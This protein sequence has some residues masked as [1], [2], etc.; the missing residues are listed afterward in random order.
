MTDELEQLVTEATELTGAAP[1]DVL[2][3]D[4]PV[5]ADDALLA[6][7]DESVYLVG[8]IG[9][10]DVGKSSLVNALAGQQITRP[11]SHGP[12]TEHAIAYAHSSAVEEVRALLEREL[13]GRYRIVAHASAALRRQVLLDLPDVDSHWSDHVLVTRRML[14][15]ILFPV[16]IQSIEKYADLAPQQL[17]AKVAEGNDPANFVFVLNKIDQLAARDG[18]AGR[19]GGAPLNELR[20]DFAK[21]IARTLSMTDSPRVHAISATHADEGDLPALRQLLAREKSGD[22]VRRSQQLAVRRRDRSLL[23]WI[24]RQGL[25]ER[26]QVLARLERDAHDALAARLGV[27][28]LERALPRLSDDPGH[29]LAMVEPALHRRLSRWPVV[30]VIDSVL[31]PLLALVRRNLSAARE[32]SAARA[33]DVYLEQEARTVASLAQ[34]AFAHL[35]QTHPLVGQLYRQHKLWE[36][37]PAEGAAADLRQRLGGA[38]DRQR[39]VIMERVAGGSGALTAPIRWLLTIGAL[40]WFPFVQPMLEAFLAGSAGTTAREL[41]YLGVQMLG[42]TYL[43]KNVTFLIIWFAVLWLVLRWGTHRRASRL[44][45]RWSGGARLDDPLSLSGQVIQWIDDLLEPI[46]RHR[47]RVEVVVK[48]ADEMRASMSRAEAA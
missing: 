3:E 47:E 21:R 35:H 31:A 24:D 23:D 25:G 27:P 41:L 28:L 43:L 17:L 8:I 46:H 29:R 48:R 12:G 45:N 44:L 42:V 36:Q 13:P 32:G 19:D 14:R 15:H 38:I 6:P 39:D 1:P 33:L 30:N 18:G 2:D 10:K 5:L 20:D 11:T 7:A 16:W 22:V 26:A 4:A 40:L 37:L 34:S 9:G